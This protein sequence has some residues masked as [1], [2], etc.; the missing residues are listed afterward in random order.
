MT[1]HPY[2]TGETLEQLLERIL[3][4]EPATHH[5][6]DEWEQT[7]RAEQEVFDRVCREENP[8]A[9]YPSSRGW[10]GT[11]RIGYHRGDGVARTGRVV[12][13]TPRRIPRR[14]RMP[15]TTR[16]PAPPRA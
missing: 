5:L 1:N 16:R 9:D 15:R 6:R 2:T 3:F 11:G 10:V 7:K 4:E 14:N 13:A 12:P 8:Q